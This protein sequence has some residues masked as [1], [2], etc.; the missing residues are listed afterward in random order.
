MDGPMSGVDPDQ[1]ENDTGTF[2]R[3]LYKLEKVFNE[4]P[5]PLKM[6]Q[7]VQLKKCDVIIYSFVCLS[8]VKSR[9]DEFKENLPL[10]GALFNPG[11]RERHWEKMSS[12]AGQDL[13]PTEV[14]T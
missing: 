1:V 4:T 3:G 10:I 14:S 12:M 8:Q 2:W 13:M 9:V 6:A 11:L 7:K 5:N